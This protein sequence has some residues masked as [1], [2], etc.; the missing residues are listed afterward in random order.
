MWSSVDQ[1]HQLHCSIWWSQFGI[2]IGTLDLYADWPPI[3][4]FAWIILHDIYLPPYLSKNVVTY[5]M[6]NLHPTNI[7]TERC[8]PIVTGVRSDSMQKRVKYSGNFKVLCNISLTNFIPFAF[9]WIRHQ[10]YIIHIK[11]S[12][13]NPPDLGF[14]RHYFK[15]RELQGDMQHFSHKFRSFHF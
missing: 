4:L 8:L 5:I 15:L 13:Q 1:L 9:Y 3:W 14:Q 7:F 11:S 12:Y 10:I 2:K 6:V